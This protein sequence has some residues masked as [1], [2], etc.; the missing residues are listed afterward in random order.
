MEPPFRS[1]LKFLTAFPVRELTDP[2]RVGDKEGLLITIG[3]RLFDD[4][5]SSKRKRFLTCAAPNIRPFAIRL[6]CL[7]LVKFE[8]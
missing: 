7:I 4:G 8:Q 3:A 6:I 5:L 2:C 1:F